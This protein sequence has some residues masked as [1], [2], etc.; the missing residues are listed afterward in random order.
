MNPG[1]GGGCPGKTGREKGE[2]QFEDMCLAGHTAGS[3]VELDSMRDFTGRHV[4]LF[5]PG[6]EGEYIYW[7]GS[8]FHWSRTASQK[9]N[10]CK[11]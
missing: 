6:I 2:S 4:E 3:S 9:F 10:S 11:F 7:W 1:H 5:V 8:N